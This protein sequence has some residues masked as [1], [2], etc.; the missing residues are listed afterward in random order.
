MKKQ[1]NTYRQF[2]SSFQHNRLQE[3]Q[4]IMFVFFFL[5]PRL[6]FSSHYVHPDHGG[7]EGQAQEEAPGQGRV[8]GELQRS[9]LPQLLSVPRGH[10]A[11]EP[12]QTPS[13]EAL[14][15]GLWRCAGPHG[16]G[17]HPHRR[18]GKMEAQLSVCAA[19]QVE[20]RLTSF[21]S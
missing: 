4:I 9:D 12:A 17:R 1:L 6:S 18:Y 21:Y 15:V 8:G 13:H 20:L 11:L 10:A 5:K 3:L 14:Q 7:G 2:P 16:E 19:R